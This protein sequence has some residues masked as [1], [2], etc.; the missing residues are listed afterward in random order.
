MSNDSNPL[1]RNTDRANEL[2]K[3]WVFE[4]KAPLGDEHRYAD[5]RT[6][7]VGY[8]NEC[9][10]CG[11]AALGKDEEGDEFCEIHLPHFQ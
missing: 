8:L 11:R 5:P 2:R 9:V 4:G 3:D 10:V 7:Y 1:K 6:P